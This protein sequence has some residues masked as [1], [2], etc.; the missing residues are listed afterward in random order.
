VIRTQ[1]AEA[2]AS[3]AAA[4]IRRAIQRYGHARIL[5]ATGTSQREF[6]EFL[7]N[8]PGINWSHVEM[9]QLDEYI[10]LPTSLAASFCKILSESFIQRV[11]ISAALLASS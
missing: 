10:G 1:W 2:A 11:G 7:I 9:F 5:V 4:S 8:A 3:H 6:Q